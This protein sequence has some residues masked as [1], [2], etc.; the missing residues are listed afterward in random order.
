[1][2]DFAQHNGTPRAGRRFVDERIR[3]GTSG[4]EYAHWRGAVY[5]PELPRDRWLEFYAE[6][7]DTV[8]INAT[9]YRLP[10]AATF[11]AWGRRVP[12]SFRFAVKASRYLT[13]VRRL[14][15]TAEP[16]NRLRRRADRLDGRLGPTLYQLPPRWRPNP[17]RFSQFLDAISA[18]SDQVI[19]IRDPRWYREDILAMIER[20]RASLCLHDMPGSAPSPQPVGPLVYVRF[21][22]AGERYGGSYS[23][24]R[25]VAWADRLAEWVAEGRRAWVFFNNDIGGHAVADASRLR[26]YVHRRLS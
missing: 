15:D 26:D 24:Q 19:E 5:P 4:W 10:E 18:A 22:G 8:E 2:R 11:E 17:E 16:V 12:A 1:L 21:H 7:F 20:S 14:R 3:I 13:H 25:L 6:R 9:F 23:A